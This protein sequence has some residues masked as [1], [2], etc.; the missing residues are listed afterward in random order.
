[1]GA[2][3]E[4]TYGT[5][6]TVTR[7]YELAK[8]GIEGKYERIESE[9]QQTGYRVL[10][11]SR[12]AH[13][14]KGAEGSLDLEVLDKGFAFWFKHMLGNVSA[15]TKGADN[16]TPFTATLGDLSGKSFTLEVGRV[17]A[18]GALT[19]FQY[20]G[21]KVGSWEITNEVDGVLN[22]SL[23]LVFSKETPRTT[24]LPTVTYPAG[25]R[26]FTYLGGT[27]TLDGSS[28]A[29]NEVSVKCDNG[30]KDDRWSIG[31][32]R[33]EPKEEKLREIEFELKG[34][35]ENTTVFN[36]VASGATG[37]LVL[38]WAGV[39]PDPAKP[40]EVPTLTITMPY[41]RFDEAPPNVEAGKL[42]EQSMSGKALASTATDAITIV[43][44]S[45][46]TAA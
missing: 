28:I 43:Y 11:A 36:K 8:E 33:R 41:A 42:S 37:A 24:T 15:G 30:L 1:M 18:A 4:V 5:G 38:V 31:L 35:F 19:A 23:D 46:D 21:G 32:G 9:A 10:A 20:A 39:A 40:A 29:V 22:L 7:F 3:D 26:L 12:F 13:N 16:M 14:P 27:F 25:S 45:L 6:V 44:K 2:V 17:D 34:D